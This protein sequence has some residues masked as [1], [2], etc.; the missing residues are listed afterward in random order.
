MNRLV[1]IHTVRWLSPEGVDD[2]RRHNGSPGAP[3]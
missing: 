2:V 1:E 3:V